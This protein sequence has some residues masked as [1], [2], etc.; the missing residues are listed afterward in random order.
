VSSERVEEIK[1]LHVNIHQPG[2]ELSGGCHICELLTA[3]EHAERA[4]EEWKQ[5]EGERCPLCHGPL[6][7]HMAAHLQIEVEES[8]RVCDLRTRLAEAERSRDGW[9]VQAEHEHAL[10]AAMLTKYEAAEQ[11]GRALEAALRDIS[12]LKFTAT[13]SPGV[14]QATQLADAALSAPPPGA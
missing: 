8:E 1:Q 11:R 7:D 5:H 10:L 3:L 6:S 13:A 12:A 4:L 9:M 14:V 2:I